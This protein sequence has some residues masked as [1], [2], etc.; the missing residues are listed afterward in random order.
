MSYKHFT[1]RER[2]QHRLGWTARAIARKVNRH[3][4]SVSRELQRQADQDFYDAEKAQESYII[5]RK[6]CK[7][8]EKWNAARQQ[9]ITAKLAE[10]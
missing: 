3:H 10:T 4:S 1:I 7:R 9:Y 6:H 2:S 5:R 8:H